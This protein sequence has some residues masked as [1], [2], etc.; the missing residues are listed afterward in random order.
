ML[1]KIIFSISVL[2]LVVFLVI[3][4]AYW[5]FNRKIDKEVANLSSNTK[6]ETII[7]SENMLE[8]LPNPV[9]RCLTYSRI[10]GKPIPHIVRLKQAGKIRQDKKSAWMDFEATEFYSIDPPSFVWKASLPSSK[11]PL[12]MG[13]DKYAEGVGSM[14]IKMLSLVSLVD[15]KGSEINQGATMRYLNEM[16]WFPASYLG[17]NVSWKA[18]DNTS[19]EITLTDEGMSVSAVIYFDEEGKITNF[20]AKRYRSVGK[21]FELETWSTP[22]TEYKEFN[23]I[24]L[25]S[26]G[27]AVW[28]LKDG[29]FEYIELEIKELE[30]DS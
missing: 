20:V 4:F 17:K 10:V 9:K 30:Y 12:V 2:L 1:R 19:A 28:N 22:I 8:D 27:K 24:K 16:M 15:A 26:K 7:V 29:D 5:N 14:N 21:R 11:T 13:L 25:P 6:T 23:G 18:I 3:G